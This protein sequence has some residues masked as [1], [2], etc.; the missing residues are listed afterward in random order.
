LSL[1]SAKKPRCALSGD[2]NG[3][4]APSVAGTGRASTEFNGRTQ[5]WSLFV[6]A[7]MLPSGDSERYFGGPPGKVI[8]KRPGESE[9]GA[10]RKWTKESA[11][12]HAKRTAAT[13][14]ANHN[15]RD[16]TGTGGD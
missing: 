1:P 4:M 6:N 2:Q 5:I 15:L 14:Q 10:S 3:N 11:A 7:S 12:V 13:A 8:G 16:S 9:S